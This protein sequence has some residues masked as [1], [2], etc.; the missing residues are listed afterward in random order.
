MHMTEAEREGAS[1][2]SALR[3]A[4]IVA[5]ATVTIADYGLVG[6]S[7]A[8]IAERAGLPDSHLIASHFKNKQQIVDEVTADILGTLQ[9]FVAQR[10]KEESTAR[11]TLLAY[12]RAHIDHFGS[13]RV[14][15]SALLA[16]F[17]YSGFKYSAA[18]RDG[19]RALLTAVLRDGQARG[20]FRDFD[21]NMMASLALSTLEGLPI[22]L[23]AR[24]DLDPTAYADAVE[25]VFDLAT[26]R[27]E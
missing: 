11:G 1:D 27:A 2:R 9:R 21:A 5:A 4:R 14:Q 22:L 23:E 13:H 10:M 19:A 20:E 18:Y 6:A 24:P 16:I 8:R 26:R 25:E 3:R 17:T 12:L 7:F 15:L